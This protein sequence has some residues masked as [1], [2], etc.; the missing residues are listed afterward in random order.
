MTLTDFNS[1][2]TSRH[3]TFNFSLL[4]F[5][6][7]SLVKNGV[8]IDAL[9]YTINDPF[10]GLIISETWLSEKTI[11]LSNQPSFKLHYSH[12]QSRGGGIS[13]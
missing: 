3:P 12:R 4:N 5:N 6:A 11:N 9:L 13:F 7:R 8:E 2:Q 1:A 10:H